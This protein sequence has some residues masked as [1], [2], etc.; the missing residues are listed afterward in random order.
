M[1]SSR[2]MF[3]HLS[4]G[5]TA[6]LLLHEPGLAQRS[7]SLHFDED[8][9]EGINRS[10][11]DR[12]NQLSEATREDSSHLYRKRSGFSDRNAVLLEEMIFKP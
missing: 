11:L 10:P 12:F 6:I 2:Q 3:F 5:I 8:M 1:M 9:I 4:V 7:K